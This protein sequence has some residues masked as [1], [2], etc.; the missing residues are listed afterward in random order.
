MKKLDNYI[1]FIDESGK[2]KFS[3]IGDHFLL[4]GLII[5]KDLH[6][7]LSS[8]MISL[9]EKSDIPTSGNI[10]A[11]DLFEDEKIRV[12]GDKKRIAY[13]KINTFF[14]R[15][16]HI[17][18]GS[19]IVCLVVRMDKRPYK[20]MISKTARRKKVSDSAI[21]NYLKREGL[22]DF[23]YET[24][25]RR[26]ILEFGY[27]LEKKDAHGEVVAESRRQ[28]DH[29]V[30]EAFL[31][32]TTTSKYRPEAIYHEWS[33]FSFKRIHGLTF[34]NKKGLSFG[35]EI[36]DLFAWS[37]FNSHYKRQRIS[38]S[39]ANNNRVDIR[40]EKT[41]EIMK[42]LCARKKPEDITSSKLKTIA[43]DRVSEFTEALKQYK[44]CSVSSGTPPGN[45]GEP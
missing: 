19:E 43:N 8:Y 17:V 38:S 16:S 44:Q 20:E 13:S 11:F 28:D 37:H 27:F 40:L 4:C 10:H 35:L 34:Q 7:A 41:E 26:L 9:K 31:S 24:L 33:K 15:L 12:E 29:A 5:N 14:T 18:Q 6:S 45:P 23:L 42:D 32:A 25:A 30:L 3:D 21:I 2:S 1:L 36:A 22:H 39:H